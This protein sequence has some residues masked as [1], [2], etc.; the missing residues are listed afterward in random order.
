MGSALGVA[1]AQPRL[2]K[3]RPLGEQKMDLVIRQA[4]DRDAERIHEVHLASVRGLCRD[5][6]DPEVIDGWLRGRSAA[7]YARGIGNGATFVAEIGGVVVGF[8]EAIPREILAVFVDPAWAG[9]G[10]GAALFSNAWERAAGLG[11]V[12]RLEATLNAAP[13]YEH[14]GFRALDRSTVRRNDVDI[15]VVVMERRV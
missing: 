11:G 6:Y 7:G 5:S 1:Y 10:V 12:V 8:C 3:P 4:T 2:L 15:P 9:Q 13:F 14:F